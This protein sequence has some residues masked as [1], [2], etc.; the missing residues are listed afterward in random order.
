MSNQDSDEIFMKI[1]IS[2]SE[3]KFSKFEKKIKNCLFYMFFLF[4]KD[5]ESHV[6]LESVSIIFQ[7]L[8]IMYYPFD[9]YVKYIKLFIYNILVCY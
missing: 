6:F 5:N 7:Y 9:S 1:N 4:L 2:E 8:Q 3:T